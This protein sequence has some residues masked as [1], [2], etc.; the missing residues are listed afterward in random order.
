MRIDNKLRKAQNFSAQME[1]ISEARLLTLLGGECPKDYISKQENTGK[2]GN[3]NLTGFK[4]IL[5]GVRVV[6]ILN[7]H[8]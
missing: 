3:T 2:N 8:R 5:V 7:K 1:C 6:Q 4:F